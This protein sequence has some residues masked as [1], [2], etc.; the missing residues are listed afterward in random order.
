MGG[1]SGTNTASDN[2][3]LFSVQ[4]VFDTMGSWVAYKALS[5]TWVT[6]LGKNAYGARRPDPSHRVT[7]QK[8]RR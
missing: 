4:A 7:D 6:G 2:V 1:Y 3:P 5:I 8:D